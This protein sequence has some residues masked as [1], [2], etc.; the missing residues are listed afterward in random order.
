[1]VLDGWHRQEICLELGVTPKYEKYLG[2]DLGAIDLVWRAEK[3]RNTTSSQWAVAAMKAQPMMEEILAKIKTEKTEKLKG[4]QNAKKKQMGESIPPIDLPKKERDDSRRAKV[5]YAKKCHTNTKYIEKAKT[6]TPD[7]L[8]Q[9][10]KGELSIGDI[11]RAERTEA[12]KTKEQE[13]A[14]ESIAVASESVSEESISVPEPKGELSDGEI[15]KIV[16]RAIK[17][18]RELE[19]TMV[20]REIENKTGE[21]FIVNVLAHQKIHEIQIALGEKLTE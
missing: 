18:V 3:R 2:D 8:V 6:L 13:K 16:R 7:V 5:Q 19:G 20:K 15:L 10:E 1:M 21:K 4:N 17:K 9:I 12:I 14:I 11:M